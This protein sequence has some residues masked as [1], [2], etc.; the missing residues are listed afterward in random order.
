M[1]WLHYACHPVVAALRFDASHSLGGCNDHIARGPSAVNNDEQSHRTWEPR[2]RVF[3]WR[4][5]LP[6]VRDKLYAI[7]LKGLPPSEY[8]PASRSMPPVYDQGQL[9]SCTG[10]AIA[11][12]MEYERDRQGL[13]DFVPSPVVHLLQRNARASKGTVSSDSGAVIR[14]RHQGGQPRG[15]FA[16]ETLWPLRHWGCFT[17]KPPKRCYVLS[18]ATDIKAVAV[19]GNPD[20][21]GSQ[22]TRSPRTWRSF[23]GSPCTRVSKSQ[24]VARNGCDGRCP[25]PGEAHR[26]WGTPCSP[27]VTQTPRAT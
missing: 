14:G 13:A 12:A 26:R 24:S 22:G 3:G 25:K 7:S 5:Q 16:R 4:P 23:S 11:A 8:E 9:G 1:E 2:P 15:V 10:N 21:A 20:A 18:A 19:R 6:D 27:S 17:V